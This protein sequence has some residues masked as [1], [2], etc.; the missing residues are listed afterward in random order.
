M[1]LIEILAQLNNVRNIYVS[2]SLE[3]VY[4]IKQPMLNNA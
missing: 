4:G 1:Y 2:K 3:F